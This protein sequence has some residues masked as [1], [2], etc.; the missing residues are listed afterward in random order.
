MGTARNAMR[1]VKEVI[2][3]CPTAPMTCV[4]NSRKPTV[5]AACAATTASA[6]RRA[7]AA[8]VRQAQA[9]PTAKSGPSVT[10]ISLAPIASAAATSD[11]AAATS[12][13]R[14]VGDGARGGD[15]RQQL[16]DQR[17]M[18]AERR[19]VGDRL[20]VHGQERPQRRRRQRSGAVAR[21]TQRQPGDQRDGDAVEHQIGDAERQRPGAE[22][23]GEQRESRRCAPDDTTAR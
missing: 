3:P 15:E 14:A 5:S 19:G 16:Q 2:A 6:R 20:D 11:A 22:R 21:Q 4:R 12:A 9:T 23:G 10:A 17:Q 7:S 13:S 8:S 18:I 1:A